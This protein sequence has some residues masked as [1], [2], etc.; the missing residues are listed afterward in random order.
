MKKNSVQV[1]LELLPERPYLVGSVPARE[2]V[3][4]LLPEPDEQR[5]ILLSEGFW[6]S[7]VRAMS[8]EERAQWCAEILAKKEFSRRYPEA[9]HHMIA[10][11]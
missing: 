6:S 9:R 7:E 8:L 10:A 5:R 1:S 2:A 4:V 11:A 3:K